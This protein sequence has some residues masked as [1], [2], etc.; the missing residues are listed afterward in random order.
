MFEQI[1]NTPFEKATLGIAQR[2]IMMS[3]ASATDELVKLYNDIDEGIK[4]IRESGDEESARI[5]EEA[6][7]DM[8]A[9]NKEVTALANMLEQK[10]GIS[11]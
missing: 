7:K 6:L 4:F 9:A 11:A 8:N 1:G 3:A 2:L 5:I 10:L